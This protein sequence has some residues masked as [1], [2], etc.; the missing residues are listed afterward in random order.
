VVSVMAKFSQ[1]HRR[2]KQFRSGGCGGQCGGKT[3]RHHVNCASMIHGNHI[4][5]ADT[6]RPTARIVAPGLAAA[7]AGGARFTALAAPGKPPAEGPSQL[8]VGTSAGQVREETR[9]PPAPPAQR[10]WL[11]SVSRGFMSH[12]HVGHLAHKKQAGSRAPAS[13]ACGLWTVDAS[14]H[15]LGVANPAAMHSFPL[16][17][18][19]CSFP[20]RCWR[21]LRNHSSRPRA[22]P[23]PRATT[24]R[25]SF[26]RRGRKQLR[27]TRRT[28]HRPTSPL[29][30][31][32]IAD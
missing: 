15:L 14:C 30:L 31:E 13:S 26:R 21:W 7:L 9:A 27:A 2:Y 3:S 28:T 17:V 24:Q 1:H 8:F 11:Q 23:P 16:D 5:E 6:L 10:L 29:R 19:P 18:H 32:G 25:P 20:S 4:Q 12:S 22:P